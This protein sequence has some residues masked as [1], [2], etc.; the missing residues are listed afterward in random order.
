MGTYLIS[1]DLRKQ[2][3]YQPLY[4]LLKQWK[5]SKLL[6]S[7]YIIENMKGNAAAIRDIIQNTIDNDDWLTVINLPANVDWATVRCDPAGVAAIKRIS[8]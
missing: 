8:P 3:N 1:Y 2:K 6:E 7:V 5:A 4:D